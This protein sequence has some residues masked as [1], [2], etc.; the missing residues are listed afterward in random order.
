VQA[1]ELARQGEWGEID[2]LQLLPS[3]SALCLK[4][5]HVYFPDEI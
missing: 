4:T 2:E 5:L 3:C 1:L